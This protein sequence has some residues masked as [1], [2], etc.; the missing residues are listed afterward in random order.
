MPIKQLIEVGRGRGSRKTAMALVVL[1]AGVGV[2]LYQGDIPHNVLSLLE[3]IFIAFVGGN[4]GEHFS[5]RG[6]PAPQ[7][8]TNGSEDIK[9]LETQIQQVSEAV[10]V[11]NQALGQLVQ[12]VASLQELQNQQARPQ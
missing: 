5:K 3:T 7:P 8:A 1:G 2:G 11:G 9:R 12:Y 4:L 6:A 10:N